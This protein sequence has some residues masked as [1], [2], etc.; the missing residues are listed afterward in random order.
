LA[1]L[2]RQVYAPFTPKQVKDLAALM[3]LGPAV[4]LIAVKSAAEYEIFH[5][6]PAGLLVAEL[7]ERF[8]ET[9]PPAS[10]VPE[11]RAIETC[12]EATETE[13]RRRVEESASRAGQHFR[14]FMSLR[15]LSWFLGNSSAGKLSRRNEALYR[16]SSG[17][18]SP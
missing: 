2:N 10:A 9:L 17:P 4:I 18:I 5:S 8:R 3:A 7:N 13:A 14:M 15:A 16:R 11:E 1:P 12:A 6:S